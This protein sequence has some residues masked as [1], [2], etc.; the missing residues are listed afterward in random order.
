[1]R[2]PTLAMSLVLAIAALLTSA[3]SAQPHTPKRSQSLLRI[4]P[5]WKIEL[6][7]A[8]PVVVDPVDIAF[9]ERGRLWVV[10]MRDYPNGPAAGEPPRSRVRVLEDED[11]DGRFEKGTTF[12]E[13]LPYASGVQPWNGGVIVTASPRVLFLEDT[14]GDGR[15]DRHETLFDGFAVDNPQLRVNSPTFA[16]DNR[17][18]VANGL[19]G[20]T[21]SRH[22]TASRHGEN[23]QPG[24]KKGKALS[25]RGRDFRFSPRSMRFEAVSGE[26]QFGMAFDDWGRRFVCSNRNPL[27]HVV[28]PTFAASRNRFHVPPSVVAD[29]TP[30]GPN[31]R[32]RPL[33]RN[34]TTSNL[35]QGTFTAACGI[36]FYRESL[37]EELRGN[38]FTCEPTG[39]LVRRWKLTPEGVTFDAR[40]ARH[41]RE[42]LASEDEWFRPVNI[43]SGPGGA[44]YVVDMCRAVIEH[45]RWMPPEQQGR[46]DLEDGNDRGRIWRIVPRKTTRRD[47]D[48]RKLPAERSVSELV[49]GLTEPDA[50]WRE[51]C[52]RLLLEQNAIGAR[53][54]LEN[55]AR[56]GRAGVAARRSELGRVHAL[57]TLEGLGV[58]ST[59]VLE[60]ALETGGPPVRESALR[61]AAPRLWYTET[62]G[63]AVARLVNFEKDKRA[64][65][66]ALLALGELATHW[67]TKGAHQLGTVA[68]LTLATHDDHWH[69]EAIL[70]FPPETAAGL[71]RDVL[72]RDSGG[73]LDSRGGR[74]L[75]RDL[76][77]IAV[78]QLLD[79]T[80]TETAK[81]RES[82]L[83]I[84]DWTVTVE[85][86]FWKCVVFDAIG[87]AARSSGVSL[88][89]LISKEISPNRPEHTRFARVTAPELVV[90]ETDPVARLE[91]I[92]FLAHCPWETSK[93]PLS[94]FLRMDDPEHVRTALRSIGAH[95][96]DDVAGLILDVWPRYSPSLRREALDVLCSTAPRAQRLLEAIQSGQVPASDVGPRHRTR[97]LG[98]KNADLKKSARLAFERPTESRG[99]VVERLRDALSIL[100][101]RIH[102]KSLFTERCATCHRVDGVG[103]DVGPDISDTRTRSKESL[104]IDIVDPNHAIDGAYVSYTAVTNAGQTHQGVIANETSSGVTLRMAEGKTVSLTYAETAHLRADGVSFMPEGLEQD[105]SPRDVADLI[106]FLKNWRYEEKAASPKPKPKPNI[107]ILLADDLGWAD[108]GYH[109]KR[110]RTPRIDRL[111]REGVELDR[112]YVCPMCSPTRGA[113][114]TG[115]FPIRFGLSRAVIPP[116]RD[117]G[118]DTSET[119]LPQVLAKAGYEHRGIFGKWHLG[120]R[121][122][123]WHPLERGFTRFEGHYNGAIDYFD[124]T[125]EGERDWHVD[126]EPSDAKGYATDLIADAA[127]RFIREHAKDS[128]FLCYVPFNAPHSPFQAP[129]KY[130]D[131]YSDIKNKRKRTL[132][133]M[134]TSL[135]DAIGRILDTIDDTKIRDNTLV[136]FFSDNGGIRAV[137]DNNL[138]LRGDK[139]SVFE[140]GVRVPAAIRWPARLEGGTRTTQPLACIDV[141]PTLMAL[142]GIKTHGGK[143]LDGRDM[144]LEIQN[145]RQTD[146]ELFFYHGQNGPKDEHAALITASWKLIVRGPD[147]S[148]GNWRTDSHR[149]FLFDISK[150]PNE[151]TDVADKHPKVVERLAKRLV[152]LRRTQPKTSVP[153]YGADRK[154]FRA[155]SKWRIPSR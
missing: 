36:A 108:V 81:N 125:R 103:I 49:D 12:A 57:W 113:L 91:L 37:L 90:D 46:P 79:Q 126:Y 47:A 6:A 137:P 153:T 144:I 121:R 9:D 51:T 88:I 74:A 109:A 142:A 146:R 155:P 95:A 30:V 78:H 24:T 120:H 106:A 66:W 70:A 34:W 31:S 15:A 26:S 104:L 17:I 99:K 111:V 42:F 55:L 150:D 133:A 11:G 116:W 119:T 75:F 63:V 134:V 131:L 114:M 92:D 138:P 50:W 148:N 3:A 149:V 27:R 60:K 5:R 56:N 53:A 18:Y 52:Q 152:E 38:A 40:P 45:P 71:A 39:N 94:N 93:N 89:E 35:H 139:L 98:S 59:S 82:L 23:D 33:T 135:D 140:G 96:N 128:P 76:L 22:S 29:I 61:L 48:V 110:F 130:L 72:Q 43:E 69:R 107:V 73:H 141:L 13:G 4:D 118:L 136:W 124:Q 80:E 10:E 154:G 21:V 32:I 67:E 127:C 123:Q 145:R 54:E 62:L 44:L 151:A 14:N 102:G 16:L 143:P 117:Y 28:L 25:I 20:G 41:D 86:E 100:G 132:G 64:R 85:A 7:A 129:Q 84:I 1:M 65:F 122:R 77:T 8:E 97:L 83:A 112:F 147:V 2:L 19:R 68:A 58:L 115:R 105:W 101:D 87:D